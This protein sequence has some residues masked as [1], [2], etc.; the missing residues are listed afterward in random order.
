LEEAVG[1]REQAALYSTP[2]MESGVVWRQACKHLAACVNKN[3]H[4]IRNKVQ[5][6]SIAC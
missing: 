4:E 6:T 3:Q 5:V 1:S 2:R